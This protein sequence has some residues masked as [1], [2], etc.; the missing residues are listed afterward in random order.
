MFGKEL[1]I[2][3]FNILQAKNNTFL[4]WCIYNLIVLLCFGFTNILKQGGK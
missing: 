3:E 2:E 4:R 1:D